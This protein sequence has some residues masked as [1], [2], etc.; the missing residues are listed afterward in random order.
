M[1]FEDGITRAMKCGEG[2]LKV[3]FLKGTSHNGYTALNSDL[4]LWACKNIYFDKYK[5]KHSKL[6]LF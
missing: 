4:Y 3:H 6:E 1:N 2:V 5:G